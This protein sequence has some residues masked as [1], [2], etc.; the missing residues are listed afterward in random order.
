MPLRFQR[1]R[2]NA[3]L[4]GQLII[5]STYDVYLDG[6]TLTYVKTVCAR[7]DAAKRFILH[8]IP[9]D[10]SVIGGNEQHTM[11]FSFIEGEDWYVGES[12]VV[13]RELPDYA[14]ASIRTGQYDISRSR[15]E[16]L[17]EYHFSRPN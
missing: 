2:A 17:S 5:R 13:S 15:H 14:I 16:W 3:P 4:Q 6:R 12:C 9:V 1:Q 11:D 8:V 10:K 7:D